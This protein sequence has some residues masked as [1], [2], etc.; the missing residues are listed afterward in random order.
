MYLTYISSGHQD[1][2]LCNVTAN[3]GQKSNSYEPARSFVP[4]S[5]KGVNSER[6]DEYVS[7]FAI[8]LDQKS[9]STDSTFI[10]KFIERLKL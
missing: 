5:R 1:E 6:Y 9:N 3:L 7:D 8:I 10:M 2:Y 4:R